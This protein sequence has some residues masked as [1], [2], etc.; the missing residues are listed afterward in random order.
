MPGPLIS[1]DGVDF[2]LPAARGVQGVRLE[3]DF[4]L[5]P[6]DPDF[7]RTG[8]EWS[9][10]L[11]RPAVDRFE[12]QF[13]LRS[14]DGTNW[15]TDPQNPDRVANP[16][17]EKSEI[18]FP[19]Y[20]PPAWLSTP[21]SGVHQTISSITG[22]LG[23]SVPVTLWSPAGLHPDVPAPLLL[24]HDGTDMAVRGSLLRWATHANARLPFRVALLD[25]APGRRDDWYGADSD[26]ADH[27]ASVVLPAIR[28][29]I[30]VSSTV[31]LGASL[32]ALS[33]LWTHHRH[34]GLLPGLA[35]QSGSYFTAVHDRQESGYSRF[36][37]ICAAVDELLQAPS[38][39][40]GSVLLTCGSVE[41]NRANN[42]QMAQALTT[43]GYQVDVHIV[44]DAHTMIGWRDAWS[45]GLERLLEQVAT[46]TS[47]PQRPT[48]R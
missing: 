24:V 33:M 36:A 21:E 4:P 2:R 6:A 3:V 10:H 40:A 35:L 44:P 47:A 38:A 48:S 42:E 45:P 18:R 26:Y 7:H 13:S 34:P 41:E 31:G 1:S 32:G 12:Y 9:L 16:F 17:G 43:Q 20:R 27:L 14:A 8:D 15:M 46:S 11:S 25:P 29:R 19:E 37:H 22:Q 5:G 30:A 39:Q 28:H 23:E